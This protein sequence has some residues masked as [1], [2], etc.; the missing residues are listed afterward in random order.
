MVVTMRRRD[1]SKRFS[2]IARP[3]EPYVQNINLINVLRAC[4]DTRVIPRSLPKLAFVVNSGPG[5]SGIVT[6]EKP[7][8]TGFHDGPDTT[9]IDGRNSDPANSDRS[10][11]QA[12]IPGDFSPRLALVG[13]FPNAGTFT[14]AFQA[15]RCPKNLPGRRVQNT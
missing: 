15:V 7:S 8:V 5:V 2:P 10:L 4:V 1:T 14:A 12:W 3:P 9:G 13:A 11:G 6:A